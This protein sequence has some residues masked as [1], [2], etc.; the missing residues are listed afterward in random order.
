[1]AGAGVNLEGVLLPE[2]EME[3]EAEGGDA[4]SCQVNVSESRPAQTTGH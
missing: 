2:E 3:V 1:M 4:F